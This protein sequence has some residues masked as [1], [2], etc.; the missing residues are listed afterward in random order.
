MKR[1]SI[2]YEIPDFRG[3][4]EVDSGLLVND[5]YNE[6]CKITWHQSREPR[7]KFSGVMESQTEIHETKLFLFKSVFVRRT[8]QNPKS[9]I[10]FKKKTLYLIK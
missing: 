1:I 3:G 9:L 7:P 5:G 8:L 4:E 2:F 6:L 10:F